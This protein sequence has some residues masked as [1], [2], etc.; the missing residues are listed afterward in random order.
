MI[1]R[2]TIPRLAGWAKLGLLTFVICVCTQPTNADEAIEREFTSGPVTTKITLTPQQPLI[3][4]NVTLKITVTSED[5]VEVLMPAFGDALDRFS[6]VDFAESDE[7][8]DTGGSIKTQTYRLQPPMSGKQA[9]PPILV[10]Y[11]DRRD[12]QRQAPEGLDAY[13]ILTDRIEFEVKSVLPQETEAK[14]E[15]PLGK[16]APV[17]PPSPAKWPWIVAVIIAAMIA[18]PFAWQAFRK[19]Q[20]KARRR[21][22]YE[23]AKNRFERLLAKGKPSAD[24]VDGFFVELS[25]IVRRYLEDRFEL[26]AP[27]LTTEEFLGSFGESPDL[28]RDHQSL[29]REFLRQA[30]LVKFAGVQPSDDDIQRSIEAAR[31]FLEETR[32]NAPLLDDTSVT[33]KQTTVAGGP[34]A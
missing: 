20:R 7:L 28:S 15:P 14:L 32:E 27:E 2:K 30:D 33:N 11:V 5:K 12:G 16:L 1:H 34:H 6:I 13:E 8:S 24:R 25:N 18:A 4:D 29:L 9:I 21:S 17:A 22:A 26:R 10:E 23:I 19:Y 31:R 3:G